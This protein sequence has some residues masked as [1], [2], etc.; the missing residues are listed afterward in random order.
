MH[1]DSAKASMLPLAHYAPI[2]KCFAKIDIKAKEVCYLLAKENIAFLTY[3]AKL[4]L[5]E[6]DIGFAYRTEDSTKAFTLKASANVSLLRSFHL[7]RFLVFSWMDQ[8]TR[9]AQRMS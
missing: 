5:E 4:Q 6:R 3:P 1:A 2:A 7:S 9:V 8:L